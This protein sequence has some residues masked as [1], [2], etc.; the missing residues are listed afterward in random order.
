MGKLM[1]DALE[2]A[3]IYGQ[4][5]FLEL[6]FDEDQISLTKYPLD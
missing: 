6:R 1:F 3:N 5:V 2:D 4:S